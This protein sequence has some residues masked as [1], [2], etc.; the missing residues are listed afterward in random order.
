MLDAFRLADS[1]SQYVIYTRRYLDD[2]WAEFGCRDHTETLKSFL[3]TY[4]H[5]SG[6]VTGRGIMVEYE[7][8]EMLLGALPKRLWR[9][10]ITKLGL[11]LL[12]PRTFVY[13]K[14][15]D[16]IAARIAAAEALRMFDFLA[17]ASI[18]MTLTSPT[19]PPTSPASTA[20][21]TSI[22]SC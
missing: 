21:P 8:T 5:I 14:L 12:E 17:L 10:A 4:D 9:K 3:T 20:S 2:L 6:V 7:R 19:A 22:T 1:L 16:W 11:N 15:K 18:P 13:G